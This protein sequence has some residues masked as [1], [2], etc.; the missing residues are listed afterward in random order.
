MRSHRILAVDVGAGHVA[1]GS[2]AGG[3]NGR[4]ILREFALEPH[5]SD[6][7][8]E[9]CWS[10]E[11]AQSFAA[12]A[13]QRRLGGVCSLGIP[14]HLALT[15]FVKTPSV[16]PE[17]RGKI[18]AFE[19][20]ENIPYPLD[21]VVWDFAV[22]ADN[23]V[24]LEV[25]LVAAKSD[26]MQ[27]LCLAADAAGFPVE[28]AIPA[29]LALCHAFHYN[30]PEVR[31][32][33]MVADIGARS[34]G[35]LF[36]EGD[37]CYLRTLPLGGNTVTHLVADDLRI[38]FGSAEALKIQI[39]SGQSELP[40]S[41]PSRA[42][43]QRAAAGFTGRLQIEIIRSAINHRRQTNA[44]APVTLYLTGGGS[45]IDALQVTL[46]EKLNLRIERFLALRRVDVAPDAHAAGAGS[47]EHFLAAL[48]G[49]A[50]RLTI[51][52]EPEAS[53]VPPALAREI[54]LRKRRPI[55]LAAAAAGL[56]ALLPPI[57]YFH[58]VAT[59][60][61]AQVSQLDDRLAPLRSLERR[62][63]ENLQKLAAATRQMTAL[64][65]G[66]ESKGNWIEFLAEL[67]HRLG[68]VE[69]V[70][71]ERLQLVRPS[72]PVDDTTPPMESAPFNGGSETTPSLS[73]A[74]SPARLILTGRLLDAAN[75]QSRVSPEAT[76]RVKRL[77]ASFEESSFVTAV[78]NERFDNTRNGVLRFDFTLLINPEKSL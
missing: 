24:D 39:F 2:F 43:V 42:A 7:A 66:Y 37:R 76:E 53:L 75:P 25:M 60:T 28:R 21:E 15:K 46:A 6:P 51:E 1:C 35:L 23:S 22:M 29:G 73:P 50:A 48:V 67:Q 62:N 63:A 33:V 20:A 61:F 34:T 27:S 16:V 38:D 58:H 69:D 57:V 45:L 10:A 14:G 65:A 52:G 49:L 12:L 44:A 71:L 32:S 47:A 5:C 30:Y 13:V 70:W 3:A 72:L 68:A 55:I 9:N 11:V 4:L 31:E 19:A 78:E 41:S 26:A 59:R 74:S 36:L 77:L 56:I 64:R 18:V 17:K 8:I 54:G 40:A